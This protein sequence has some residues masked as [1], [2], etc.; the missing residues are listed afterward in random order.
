MSGADSAGNG[1]KPERDHKDYRAFLNLISAVAKNIVLSLPRRFAAEGRETA[2][3]DVLVVDV[4]TDRMFPAMGVGLALFVDD[5]MLVESE[6]VGENH[7]RFYAPA[8]AK[9]RSGANVEL[10]IAGTGVPRR[11][12][13]RSLKL[14]MV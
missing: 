14:E 13:E 8:N 2:L 6:A 3:H 5:E 7:Y 12:S 4:E 10:G 11:V 9:W 1:D